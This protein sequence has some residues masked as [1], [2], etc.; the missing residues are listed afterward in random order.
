[1]GRRL[2]H[3]SALMAAMLLSNQGH[4]AGSRF[5]KSHPTKKYRPKKA[6]GPINRAQENERRR[7]QIEKGMIWV[8]GSWEPMERAPRPK[9][10]GPTRAARR[11]RMRSATVAGRP[12]ASKKALRR[13][14]SKALRAERV[15]ANGGRAR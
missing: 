10:E 14:R 15:Q 8:T 4:G 1:M 6:R 3:L 13:Q 5:A 11:R 9:A 12:F 2:Q 7:R